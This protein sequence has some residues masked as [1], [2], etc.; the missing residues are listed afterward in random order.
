MKYIAN[1]PPADVY[2]FEH[3]KDRKEGE[4]LREVFVNLKSDVLSEFILLSALNSP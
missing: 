1:A 3:C 4:D 2:H